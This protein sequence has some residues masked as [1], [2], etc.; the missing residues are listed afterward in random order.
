MLSVRPIEFFEQLDLSRRKSLFEVCQARAGPFDAIP[1]VES[2]MRVK[3]GDRQHSA[4]A[5]D[6]DPQ[7]ARSHATFRA[8]E[9]PPRG[10]Q[11]RATISA[12]RCGLFPTDRETFVAPPTTIV[13]VGNSE[14][15]FDRSVVWSVLCFKRT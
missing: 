5:D 3:S 14:S 2:R 12:G 13:V 1:Q 10:H 9:V 15:H 6:G 4:K 7:A 8:S 11:L